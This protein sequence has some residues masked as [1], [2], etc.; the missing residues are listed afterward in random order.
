METVIGIL[1]LIMAFVIVL[2]M[3]SDDESLKGLWILCLACFILSALGGLNLGYK[4]H[5]SQT[6][7]QESSNE[8]YQGKT[9]LE[10]RYNGPIE[11]DSVVVYKETN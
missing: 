10:I 4:F 6:I 7:H 2:M 9:T 11:I 3:Y 5:E 1:F 8:V